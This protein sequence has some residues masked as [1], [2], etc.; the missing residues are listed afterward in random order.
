MKIL[1]LSDIHFGTIFDRT[2][3]KSKPAHYYFDASTGRSRPT[4]LAN[5]IISD[6]KLVVPPT[7]V[8]CSGDIGWSGDPEDYGVAHEFFDILRKN[9][10][11]TTFCIVPG[12]HDV[13]LE[14]SKDIKDRTVKDPER[15]DYFFQ[16]LIEFYGEAQMQILFPLIT[17]KEIATKKLIDRT[18]LIYLNSQIEGAL[19]L[20]INSAAEINNIGEAVKVSD[21]VKTLLQRDVVAKM[22]NDHTRVKICTVHHH[23]FPFV[24]SQFWSSHYD[25]A[26]PPPSFDQSIIANSADLQ[27]WLKEYNFDLVCHGHKHDFHGRE[28]LLWREGDDM[29]PR[30]LAVVG[31]GSAGV[32]LGHLADSKMHSHNVIDVLPVGRDRTY[33]QVSVGKH[34][35]RSDTVTVVHDSRRLVATGAVERALP[36]R[37]EAD[38][39]HQCHALIKACME[40]LAAK[41]SIAIVQNFVSVVRSIVEDDLERVNTAELDGQTATAAQ[42]KSCFAALHPN[43]NSDTTGPRRGRTGPFMDDGAAICHEDRLFRAIT[44]KAQSKTPV[45][46]AFEAPETRRYV[47]LYD[48]EMALSNDAS[49]LPGLVGVQFVEREEGR[50]VFID[51]VMSFRNIDLK[52]WW[53]V[54]QLEGHRLLELGTRN[55]PRRDRGYEFKRGHVIVFAARA[56]WEDHTDAPFLSEIDKLENELAF[57]EIVINA[58]STGPR[59]ADARAYLA[60]LFDEYANSLNR[61]NLRTRHVGYTLSLFRAVHSGKPP[62]S[63]IT[64]ILTKLEEAHKLTTRLHDPTAMRE[65]YEKARKS[66]KGVFVRWSV[67]GSPT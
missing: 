28:D 65:D 21:A 16:F 11:D 30:R 35:K 27:V 7:I 52:F 47:S 67:P 36:S 41:G 37:F 45:Q 10:P 9:W 59:V 60:R 14:L 39:V 64:D 4:P 19:L 24:E 46:I 63:D 61:N 53:V 49:I 44:G 2:T 15:Q 33:F 43:W 42:F 55:I 29:A 20:G 58:T 66:L 56:T 3:K 31:S 38:K 12:N 26:K 57:I 54:N 25:P 34:I 22:C 5:V 23:L 8:I 51:I 50:D 13:T 18:K 48:A 62:E 1:H 40:G 17:S 6:K 32:E